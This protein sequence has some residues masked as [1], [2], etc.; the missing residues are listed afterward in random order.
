MLPT[1][2]SALILHRRVDVA[3]RA[4]VVAPVSREM[5]AHVA[6]VL[7]SEH[8]TVTGVTDSGVFPPAG[9]SVVL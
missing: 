9:S 8:R 5:D 1:W 7:A 4:V 6:V 3:G 2:G